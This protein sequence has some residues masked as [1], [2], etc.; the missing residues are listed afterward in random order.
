MSHE[1]C[2]RERE[3]SNVGSQE[4]GFKSHSA[5]H[6][7]LGGEQVSDSGSSP[8]AFSPIGCHK[9]WTSTSEPTL[10][11]KLISS[12]KLLG[13][14]YGHILFTDKD[15]EIGAINNYSGLV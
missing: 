12:S 2:R 13:G 15:T 8:L 6:M 11:S 5:S 4:Q 14:V 3:K 10:S 1:P 9:M 7:G